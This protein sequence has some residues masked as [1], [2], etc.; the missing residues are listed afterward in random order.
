MLYA[1]LCYNNEAAVCSWTK[2]EDDAVMAKLDDAALH[3]R[4]AR[5]Q[6]TDWTQIDVL[7]AA[8]EEVQPSPVVRLNRASPSARCAGPKRRSA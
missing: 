1:F 3:A 6:D 4:A 7:Y 2:E 8:L 5:P